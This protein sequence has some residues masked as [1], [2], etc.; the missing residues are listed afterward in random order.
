MADNKLN[1]QQARQVRKSKFSDMLLDQ[2]AQKDTGVLGAVG[3]TISLR[4]QA[5]IKGI[6]EKFDP[7]N[8]I[9][10]MTM[11]SRFGP[12]LFGK[13]TGRNQK[14]IDYFTGRTKSVVGTR[15]TADKLKKSGE[16]DSE[17][18]N[19]Q[20]S[21]I[22][23]FLKS[24]REDDIRLNQISKNFDEELAMEK[25]KRHKELIATLQK[26]MKQIDSGG[27]VTATAV[28][29]SSSLIDGILASLRNVMSRVDDILDSLGGLDMARKVLPWL[30]RLAVNPLFL[31]PILVA[32]GLWKTAEGFKK[33]EEEARAAA[34]A[35]DVE[36]LRE[37]IKLQLG[38][39]G[40]MYANEETIVKRELKK[41]GTPEALAALKKLE[42]G[43]K[44]KSA[45]EKYDQYLADK[46]YFKSMGYKNL[47]R[48]MV[49]D[50]LK[51]AAE[52]YAFG[53]K[54]VPPPPPPEPLPKPA[55]ASL[56]E[57]LQYPRDRPYN[58]VS[59][60]PDV[61]SSA[62]P[63]SAIPSL[64]MANADLNLPRPL[65]NDVEPVVT[66]TAS[67]PN[68]HQGDPLR[69]SEISI[70]NNEPTFMRLLR[71]STVLV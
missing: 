54:P 50:Y 59:P 35:G 32:G 3:K 24:T 29:D 1:Y 47:K 61:V 8:I 23:S 33:T 60:V 66:R 68:I 45:Q 2:L 41:A 42:E 63:S 25:E 14:D 9:K 48:E 71:D 12:A 15:N 43:E 69:P 58:N 46:G 37:K 39:E 34:A 65:N 19:K 62:P 22:F 10:F 13:M 16:G 4:G 28:K 11:G 6:K 64:S 70:R 31:I 26:L 7:L 51:K 36:T 56:V 38:E 53:L 44:P 17:G 21:K 40:A 49:P 5:R 67:L 55:P 30:A 20:L 18:I 27:G 57:P 52:I